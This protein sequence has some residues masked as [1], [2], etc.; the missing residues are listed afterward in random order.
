MK[1]VPQW[2][3]GPETPDTAVPRTSKDVVYLIFASR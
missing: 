3:R 2:P 1:G